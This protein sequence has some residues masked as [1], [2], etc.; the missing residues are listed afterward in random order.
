MLSEETQVNPL[1]RSGAL[2]RF[3]LF[4]P[5]QVVPGIRQLLAEL[6]GE[7]E[8][9]EARI[10]S[11]WDDLVVPLERMGERLA[12]A[13]GFVGH[14]MAVRNGEALR[15]A[16]AAVQPEVV[17]FGLRQ[18]QSRAIHDGL[19]A[20]RRGRTSP[21]STRPS[22]GSSIACCATRAMRASVSTA[23]RASASTRSR[24]S[25]RSSRRASTTTCSTRRGSTA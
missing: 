19:L 21:T 6:A 18:A 24:P 20:L 4:T 10:V 22:N 15:E 17:A 5:D 3:D 12:F 7:L 2:P 16:H 25:S 9:L 23:R 1:L 14:M 11:T 13:W 8:R